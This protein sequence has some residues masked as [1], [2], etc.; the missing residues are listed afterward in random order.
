[1]HNH[2]TTY[3]TVNHKTAFTVGEEVSPYTCLRNEEIFD[4]FDLDMDTAATG[5]VAGNLEKTPAYV[6]INSL[7]VK[8]EYF[9]RDTYH[10]L[11]C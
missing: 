5:R 6:T 11:V 8:G 3:V 2:E 1:M 7:P 9:S 10:H 4:C